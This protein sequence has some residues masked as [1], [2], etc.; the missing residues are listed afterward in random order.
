MVSLELAAPMKKSGNAGSHPPMA[1]V[2]I[3]NGYTKKLRWSGN[4]LN[5]AIK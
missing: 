4:W 5:L 1:S 3:I 2:Q